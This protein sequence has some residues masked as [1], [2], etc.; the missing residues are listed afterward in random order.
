MKFFTSLLLLLSLRLDATTLPGLRVESLGD[1]A[2]FTTSLAIDSK[3]TLYYSTLDGAIYR[4]GERDAVASVV[5]DAVG[6]SGL[7]GMALLDDRFAVVHY[8]TPGQTYDVVSKIDLVTGAETILHAFVCDIELPER[9]SNSEH[10][11]GN[12][13]V[14]PDGSI[15]VGIGDFG[16]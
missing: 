10:H 8:T 15:Y 2:S 3:G 5:T 12:P 13:S 9:G 11:G 14:A 6:N 1:T 16:G 7:L 4:L